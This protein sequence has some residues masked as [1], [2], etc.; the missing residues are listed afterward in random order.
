MELTFVIIFDVLITIMVIFN[1][2]IDWYHERCVWQ[3]ERIRLRA[4]I[5]GSVKHAYESDNIKL[6]YIVRHTYDLKESREDRYYINVDS[7][8]IYVVRSPNT[9]TAVDLRLLDDVD[10]TH[11]KSVF[12]MYNHLKSIDFKDYIFMSGGYFIPLAKGDKK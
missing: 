11:F 2:I 3:V 10:V 8:D 12:H 4:G 1:F 7:L 6:L 9:S 5:T